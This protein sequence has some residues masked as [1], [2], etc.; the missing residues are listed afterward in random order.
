MIIS[1]DR[2][3][4]LFKE[5]KEKKIYKESE[6]LLW[7]ECHRLSVPERKKI[8]NTLCSTE[9]KPFL[10]ILRR[11]HGK[12]V[13]RDPWLQSDQGSDLTSHLRYPDAQAV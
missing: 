7:P 8:P 4:K 9:E 11:G 1:G 6:S 3:V 2:E 12:P 10:R 5:R 13:L